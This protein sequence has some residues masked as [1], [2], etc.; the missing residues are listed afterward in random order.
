MNPKFQEEIK[1]YLNSLEEDPEKGL[2]LLRRL[3][4]EDPKAYNEAVDAIIE[5][6][7]SDQIQALSRMGTEQGYLALSQAEQQ[8]LFSVVGSE[9]LAKE[10]SY[11]EVMEVLNNKDL[12]E[13]SDELEERADKQDNVDYAYNFEKDLIDIEE[14]RKSLMNGPEE[15]VQTFVERYFSG[16]GYENNK[17]NKEL[18][19]MRLWGRDN[20]VSDIIRGN[21]K[22]TETAIK[23]FEK[24]N[25]DVKFASLDLSAQ[26]RILREA[27][28]ALSNDNKEN[29]DL[30]F[31]NSLIVNKP[32]KEKTKL[33]QKI[34]DEAKDLNKSVEELLF[35]SK[36]LRS[37]I[38]LAECEFKNSNLDQKV[39]ENLDEKIFENLHNQIIK[40]RFD[41]TSKVIESAKKRIIESNIEKRIKDGKIEVTDIP[42][43]SEM[44]FDEKRDF[45]YRVSLL[46]RHLRENPESDILKNILLN[47][48]LVNEDVILKELI[49]RQ[50]DLKKNASKL[51]YDEIKQFLRV[52]VIN[53][54]FSENQ[55]LKTTMLQVGGNNL[56]LTFNEKQLD[57]KFINTVNRN[58]N[59][60]ADV[61]KDAFISG[62][63]NNKILSE[64]K[65]VLSLDK[66]TVIDDYNFDKLSKQAA[67]KVYIAEN[68][69]IKKEKEA[70]VLASVK[71]LYREN[72]LFRSVIY[73]EMTEVVSYM[74]ESPDSVQAKFFGDYVPMKMPKSL[75]EAIKTGKNAVF[76]LDS[77][78]SRAISA[79][80]SI[81]GDPKKQVAD[82]DRAKQSQEI[83]RQIAIMT[84]KINNLSTKQNGREYSVQAKEILG[85]NY[86]KIYNS[87]TLI[88]QLVGGGVEN[89]SPA[90]QQRDILKGLQTLMLQAVKRIDSISLYIPAPYEFRNDPKFRD[91]LSLKS[92]SEIVSKNVDYGRF[93]VLTLVKKGTNAV[94]QT[95]M[96]QDFMNKDPEYKMIVE[97]FNRRYEKFSETEEKLEDLRQSLEKLQGKETGSSTARNMV[98]NIKTAISD[99]EKKLIILE[100]YMLKAKETKESYEKKFAAKLDKTAKKQS[101]EVNSQVADIFTYQDVFLKGN[102]VPINPKTDTKLAMQIRKVVNQFI[103]NMLASIDRVNETL[104]LRNVKQISLK[105]TRLGGVVKQ[106]GIIIKTLTEERDKISDELKNLSETSEEYKAKKAVYIR[107]IND[108]SRVKND[109]KMLE[110]TFDKLGIG[111]LKN[112]Q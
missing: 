88:T 8:K 69:K 40:D 101:I 79:S 51:S 49:S 25:K 36:Q 4:G 93:A 89:E 12:R 33:A 11:H 13:I 46:N 42:D 67:E 2:E 3:Q 44:D 9:E 16:S 112:K 111:E 22:E 65:T 99:Q 35:A 90:I 34:L 97:E 102:N 53:S 92:S 56:L 61:L 59:I 47:T 105:N 29:A 107:I 57:A 48:H 86:N 77:R 31:A 17:H 78:F 64:I 24:E 71:K 73:S 98:R 83:R 96:Q 21:E 70:E 106:S 28:E 52:D 37:E 14:L 108:L 81:I 10:L 15:D 103:S 45:N 85:E 55:S 41:E 80:S 95:K 109:T 5:L 75:S 32:A 27:Y 82:E 94:A 76:S 23:K 50:E 91:K 87:K 100:S 43:P 66:E 7:P 60:R 58:K 26:N 19:A 104:R 30:A 63:E 39:I 20:V 18:I 68:G 74:S 54:Y 1:S 38:G 72:Y 84:D 110:D 62:K 6:L